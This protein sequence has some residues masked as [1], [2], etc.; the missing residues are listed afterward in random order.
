MMYRTSG[1]P[2]QAS[3]T[4]LTGT[5]FERRSEPGDSRGSKQLAGSGQQFLDGHA[6]DAAADQFQARAAR[7][8]AADRNLVAGH[9]AEL[10]LAKTPLARS[11]AAVAGRRLENPAG[12]L[13]PDEIQNDV[14]AL[15]KR[16]A[17]RLVGAVVQ[18]DFYV[19]IDIGQLGGVAGDRD[20][21]ARA[22]V[23]SDLRS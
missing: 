1:S 12:G 11:R 20:H 10:Y 15:I 16:L 18:G 4:L 8:V 2:P 19:G 7:H 14:D 23:A 22:E 21:L 6:A 17:Q 5:L 9:G 13:A 3:V